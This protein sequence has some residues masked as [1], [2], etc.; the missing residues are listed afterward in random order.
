MKRLQHS[1]WQFTLVLNFVFGTRESAAQDARE[2]V[3]GVDARTPRARAES[4]FIEG[5]AWVVR[6]EEATAAGDAAK[7]QEY[8]RTAAERLADS[9]KLDPATGTL[10]N[11]ALCHEKLGQLAEAY[12]EFQTALL[13]A[14]K[15]GRNERIQFAKDHLDYIEPRLA[16]LT[17]VVPA[18][19]LP[20]GY[21]LRRSGVEIPPQQFNV[22]VPIDPG[23]YEIVASAPGYVSFRADAEIAASQPRIVLIPALQPVQVSSATP[24]Q[25]GTKDVVTT[26]RPLTT[27]IYIAGGATLALG[28]ATVVTG[29]IALQRRD[30]YNEA[31]RSS[32][33]VQDK[34]DA[35]STAQSAALVSTLL[36]VGTAV[37]A[38]ITVYLYATRPTQAR[39]AQVHVTPML[40]PGV[41]SLTLSGAF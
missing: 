14:R 6:A 21:V 38:G 22:A 29:I 26:E 8:Y 32:R 31:N 34:E 11:L 16:R 39:S 28:A 23:R 9:Y 5:R 20:A 36:G 2:E 25:T 33:S 18:G 37:G 12:R 24:N 3:P 1:L 7:A 15:A 40:G 13:E 41:A 10:L 35:R 4:L 17:L 30:E 19:Q 27:P